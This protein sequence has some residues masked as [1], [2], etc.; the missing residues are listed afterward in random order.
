MKFTGNT[1]LA[2]L[3]KSP[4][5]IAVIEKHLPG[6]T[7]NPQVRLLRSY[8]L[9]TV[10]SSPWM[11]EFIVPGVEAQV[12]R[13]IESLPD[14]V[15]ETDYAQSSPPANSREGVTKPLSG[16]RVVEMATFVAAPFCARLMADWGA[17]VVKIEP[18]EGDIYRKYGLQ[19]YFPVEDDENPIFCLENANKKAWPSI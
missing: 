13:E 3:L 10:I 2:L 6:F 5:A 9:R 4:A 16:V 11:Q 19:V 8:T 18:L 15:L 7:T 17:E 1:K 14:E 12:I